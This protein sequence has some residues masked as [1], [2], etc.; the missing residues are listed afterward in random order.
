VPLK[1]ELQNGDVVEVLTTPNSKPSRDWLNSVV[2][3]KA[4]NRIRHWI[5][6][7]QRV[8]SIDIGRKLLE[9]EA[10]KFH[11]CAEEATKF[12]ELKRI[13]NEYG[14]GRGEDLLASIGYG[15]TLPRNVLAKFL[16]AEKFAELDPE[17]KKE[18]RLESGMKAVKKF[19]WFGRDAIIVKGVDN[20]LTNRARCCNP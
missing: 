2:T 9:K 16:G 19:H 3:S 15:K 12:D 4:R 11:R 6:E 17:K 1:T 14:L 10:L 5:S 7:Q 8:E 18:T 20:L 13:A